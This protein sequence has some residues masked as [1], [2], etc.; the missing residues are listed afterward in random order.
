MAWAEALGHN[1]V[2]SEELDRPRFAPAFRVIAAN[3]S[4]WPTPQQFVECLPP[5]P[6]QQ[7]LPHRAYDPVKAAENIAR[8]QRM[9]RGEE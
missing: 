1:R 9:L 3:F 6:V 4:Q 5:R 2:W 8:I 7:A